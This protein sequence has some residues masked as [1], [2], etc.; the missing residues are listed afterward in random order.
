MAAGTTKVTKVMDLIKTTADTG[1]FEDRVYQGK[2][3]HAEDDNHE[4]A[5][6]ALS[7][8][9]GFFTFAI[10]VRGA[11]TRSRTGSL[12]VRGLVETPLPQETTDDGNT[13]Y[14]MIEALFKSLVKASTFEDEGARP[15]GESFWSPVDDEGAPKDGIA[16]FQLTLVYD[17]GALCEA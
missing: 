17:V 5:V 12:T 1:A 16:E 3:V 13:V 8:G 11:G 9:E 6:R 4:E 2:K 7:A 14:D 10:D 15:L